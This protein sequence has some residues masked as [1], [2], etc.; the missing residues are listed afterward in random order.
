MFYKRLIVNDVIVELNSFILD[1][2]MSD[3]KISSNI[4]GFVKYFLMN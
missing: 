2:R 3:T 4:K 1:R